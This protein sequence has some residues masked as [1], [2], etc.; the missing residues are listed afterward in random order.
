MKTI[1]IF[2]SSPGDVWE[3][4]LKAQQVITDLQRNY[5]SIASLEPVLWEDLALPAT[6]SFQESIDYLLEQKPIEIAVFM[7]K[8]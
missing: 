3:E 6:A 2:I 8:V 1:R 4:R 5:A 7:T